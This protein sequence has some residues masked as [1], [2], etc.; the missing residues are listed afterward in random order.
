MLQLHSDHPYYYKVTSASG[1]TAY[2]AKGTPL[3][4]KFYHTEGDV[5]NAKLRHYR[6]V[7]NQYVKNV[8]GK[9]D[10]VRHMFA[11]KRLLEASP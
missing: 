1:E 6:F 11:I 9:R 2:L 5:L 7:S 8:A 3:I 10:A 4:M